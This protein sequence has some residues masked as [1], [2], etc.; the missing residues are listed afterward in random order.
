MSKLDYEIS[1]K[2][3]KGINSLKLQLIKH[4]SRLPR[5]FDILDIYEDKVHTIAVVDSEANRI[6]L[7][8]RLKFESNSLDQPLIQFIDNGNWYKPYSGGE[9]SI[10]IEYIDRVSRDFVDL[11]RYIAGTKFVYS[12]NIPVYDKEGIAMVFQCYEGFDVDTCILDK[13]IE[14]SKGESEYE[15]KI[16]PQELF[17]NKTALKFKLS[18]MGR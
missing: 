18:T 9:C 11:N 5:K 13:H 4:D 2:D 3:S 14:M 8:F 10:I 17:G 15:A 12:L 16:S 6:F 7:V 1:W